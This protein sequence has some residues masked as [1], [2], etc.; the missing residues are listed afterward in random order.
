MNIKDL[1]PELKEKARAC[2]TPEE[3]FELAK[4][5]GM[6]IPLPNTE[7]ALVCL[8]SEHVPTISDNVNGGRRN[9]RVPQHLV[10][11][12]RAPKVTARCGYPYDSATCLSPT[13]QQ[14]PAT[15]F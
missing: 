6:E 12:A 10:Y 7:A 1:S 14:V 5:E 8:V 15:C 9:V 13:M 2:H 3:L 4:E 11:F